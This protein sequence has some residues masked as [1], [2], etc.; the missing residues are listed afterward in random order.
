MHRIVSYSQYWAFMISKPLRPLKRHFRTRTRWGSQSWMNKRTKSAG[1][2][3]RGNI[4]DRAGAA[5][6]GFLIAPHYPFDAAGE[7]EVDTRIKGG[8]AAMFL[9]KEV[10]SAV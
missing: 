8:I 6:H 3:G 1:N 10:M 5:S 7:F 2:V 4:V 9:V